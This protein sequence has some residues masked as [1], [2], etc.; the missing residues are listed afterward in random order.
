MKYF[1]PKSLVGIENR[2][3]TTLFVTV[4][5]V[6]ALFSLAYLIICYCTGVIIGVYTNL[7]MLP[8]LVLALMVF[9]YTGSFLYGSNIAAFALTAGIVEGVLFSGSLRSPAILWLMVAPTMAFLLGSKKSGIVWS[10][11][12]SI[13][14]II[15]AI[16]TIF[17]VKIPYLFPVA[18]ENYYLAFTLVAVTAWLALVI[19]IY[20]NTKD[21]AMSLLTSKNDALVKSEQHLTSE[22][23][24]GA[25]YVRSLLPEPLAK[26]VKVQ[27]RFQPSADLGGDSFGYHW[28]A[29]DKL[30]IYLLDVSG[31]GMSAALLSV[32]VLNVIRAESLA[33]ADFCDPASVLRQLNR[34]FQM[35]KQN[36]LIFTIWYGVFDAATRQLTFASGGHPPAVLLEPADKIF[37]ARKLS[38]GG[39]VLGLDPSS[40]FR[41]DSC[42][43]QPGCKLYIF[44]DGAYEISGQNGHTLQLSDLIQ[45]LGQPV[46]EK[47][48]KLESILRWTQEMRGTSVLEDDLSL[49]E[50]EL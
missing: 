6:L 45:E 8:L 16:V 11:I 29:N 12:I 33:G 19:A 1:Y 17:H 9:K 13:V 38:T 47:N 31:H 28:L 26:P 35:D 7:I 2:R 3:K 27:W 23:A 46:T 49:M 34:V 10:I 4:V 22:L 39:R 32:S 42:A 41:S 30:A 15:F 48:S 50:L 25:D 18:L 5:S 37:R 40:E 44:S 24:A 21:R 14:F 43:V 36:S 20:E